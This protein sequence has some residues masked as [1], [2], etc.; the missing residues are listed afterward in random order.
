MRNGTNAHFS[1]K[2]DS[3]EMNLLTIAFFASMPYD[4][5]ILALFARIEVYV[6]VLA[7]CID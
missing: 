1:L 5:L 3:K 6:C 7:L 4:N 2:N